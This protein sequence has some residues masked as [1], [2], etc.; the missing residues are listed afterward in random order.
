MTTPLDN[1]GERLVPGES[2]DI[3]ETIRHKSSYRFFKSIILADMERSE[4]A[5]LRI[6]D[7]GCGVGHGSLTLSEIPNSIVVGIDASAAA[8]NYANEHYNSNNIKFF[9]I[10]AEEYLKSEQAF[11]Y[12]VSRHAI[13]HIPNGIE[14]AL[15][16]KYTCRLIINVPYLE[17][18]YDK[19]DDRINPHHEVN[20]ISE[21]N[22]V[23]YPNREF[24][25]EDLKG[26]TTAA[27]DEANSIICVSSST[28]LPLVSSVISMP[29]PAWSP[30]R[31]E[32]IGLRFNDEIR[33]VRIEEAQ[34]IEDLQTRLAKLH[35]ENDL[36]KTE[37]MRIMNRKS[38]KAIT[39]IAGMTYKIFKIK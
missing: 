26:L 33:K 31:L 39:R 15:A 25:Y 9:A 12:I 17:A 3:N 14:I 5:P 27:P 6:L 34:K 19:Y 1:H 8:I 30:N 13:E 21:Q 18:L 29:Y 24:F 36:L 28:P 16:F 38:V 20:E 10:K 22:F 2:H 11:D 4:R 37:N 32:E 35:V 23:N 7:L